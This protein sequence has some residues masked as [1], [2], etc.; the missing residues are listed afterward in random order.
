MVGA[1]LSKSSRHRTKSVSQHA[2]EL[3]SI[4]SPLIKQRVENCLQPAIRLKIFH[5]Q[6]IMPDGTDG[7]RKFTLHQSTLPGTCH[8]R[9]QYKMALPTCSTAQHSL[10]LGRGGALEGSIRVALT[11]REKKETIS[12]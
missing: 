6:H 8:T 3:P 12:I 4:C 7:E 1:F 11:S 10:Q 2:G 5:V 9:K